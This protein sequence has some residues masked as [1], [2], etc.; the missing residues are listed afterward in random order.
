MNANKRPRI[1]FDVEKFDKIRQIVEEH[2]IE[3]LRQYYEEQVFNEKEEFDIKKETERRLKL[4]LQHRNFCE[5][6]IP[7]KLC[8]LI[9]LISNKFSISISSSC[10]VFLFLYYGLVLC[11]NTDD[12]IWDMLY[13]LRL[14]VGDSRAINLYNKI[15]HIASA[16]DTVCSQVR[17]TLLFFCASS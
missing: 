14:L 7:H 13:T 3:N 9:P 5:K 8:S 10:V 1:S 2:L 15:V 12:T 11:E 4:D 17:R 6:D 16:T